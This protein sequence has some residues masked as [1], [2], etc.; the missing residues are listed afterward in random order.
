VKI[1]VSLLRLLNPFVIALLRSP[2]HGV[3][4]KDV[5]LIRFT[6]RRSGR[7][8][9]TPVSYIQEGQTVR[10]FTGSETRWWRNLRGGASVSLRIRGQDR[11]GRA[12]AISGEPKRIADA[13]AAFLTRLPRDAVYYEVA[14]DS[15]KP[16]PDDVARAAQQAILVE[17][18]LEGS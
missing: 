1:P 2:L 4:S 14:L 12:E 11:R 6:G 15:G 13:L 17:I 18:A 3:M 16:R 10:C 5:M 8:F 7:T 9:T